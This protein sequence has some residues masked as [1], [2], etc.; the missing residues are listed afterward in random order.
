MALLEK[1][2][3]E[4]VEYYSNENLSIGQIAT[5]F[6]MP[7]STV[8]YYLKKHRVERRSRSEA[9]TMWYI[10]EFGKKPFT[11]K[12]K[13]SPKEEGLKLSGTM[14]YWAEGVK[15]GNSVKF[16]NSD[17]A[18][19]KLFLNFLREVCGISEGRLKLL[20]HMYPDHNEGFLKK[21]WSE[22]TG[23]HENNF[24]RSYVHEG[25]KGTYKNKSLYGTLAVNYSDKKLLTQINLW[26]QEHRE[27]YKLK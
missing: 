26:I 20:I 14:L 4:I 17:P 22:V 2:Q 24:Y 8:A 23:V 25:K 21:F 12:K 16:V 6:K 27:N 11:L 9:V 1:T 7:A 10:T 19:V 13:L 18:M 3:L 15:G 5:K